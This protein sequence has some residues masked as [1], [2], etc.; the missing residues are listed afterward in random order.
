MPS[1]AADVQGPPKYTLSG[2]TRDS[3]EGA[4]VMTKAAEPD[5]GRS[6][7]SSSKATPNR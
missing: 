3:E 7:S 1:V 2:S 4:F 5:D 6:V